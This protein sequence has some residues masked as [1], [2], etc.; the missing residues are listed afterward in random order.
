MKLTKIFDRKELSE[1]LLKLLN[2]FELF[3]GNC[4]VIDI[5]QDK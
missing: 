3:T 4:S 2:I 1:L 5:N